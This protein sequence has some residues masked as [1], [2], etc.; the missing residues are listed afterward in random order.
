[1][2]RMRKLVD[3]WSP[4]VLT[5]FLWVKFLQFLKIIGI[6][7]KEDGWRRTTRVYLRTEHS[8]FALGCF[9]LCLDSQDELEEGESL[10]AK[11]KR[12]IDKLRKFFKSQPTVQWQINCS[13]FWVQKK[14][15]SEID[16]A[17]VDFG[18]NGNLKSVT[19]YFDTFSGVSRLEGASDEIKDIVIK[20]IINSYNATKDFT[21]KK[22][23]LVLKKRLKEWLKIQLRGQSKEVKQLAENLA[24][25]VLT[26][27][28][29]SFEQLDSAQK[30]FE[31]PDFI[32][33]K[34]TGFGFLNIVC[35]LVHGNEVDLWFQCHHVCEDGMPMQEVL[36]ALKRKWGTYGK[37]KIPA[38]CCE[39]PQ[40][41]RLFSSEEDGVYFAGGFISFTPFL[42][43]IKEKN[44]QLTGGKKMTPFRFFIWKLGNHPVFEGKK[45]IIPIDLHS[46]GARERSLGFAIIRP[47]IFFDNNNPQEGL[48][49]FQEEFD[50]QVKNTLLR[51]SETYE[52]F[53][54]YA[55]SPPVFYA[56]TGKIMSS[57]LKEL[58][59]S[60]GV[61]IIDKADMFVAPSS[62][63]QTDGFISL[64][65]FFTATESGGRACY[66]SAKGP[67]D[68]VKDYLAAIAEV[69]SI[70]KI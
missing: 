10:D 29:I 38:A 34:H 59:G 22:R 26:S 16:I 2:L 56:L 30:R 37:I 4:D 65:S 7:P 31:V 47:S 28:F 49:N 32:K 6:K 19:P 43:C 13:W 48:A 44:K 39:K 36:Q 46:T 20:G 35:R 24:E 52:L 14:K 68:K 70:E 53:E 57:A 58:T 45:I 64:S 27:T 11:K 60:I 61:S 33:R 42:K 15:K 50:Q 67:K 3:R 17:Y 62:D 40:E 5:L 69:A 54:S 55:I 66:V 8:K 18:Q 51:K 41:P 9:R 21:D 25:R 12:L 63:I 1:M 23:P